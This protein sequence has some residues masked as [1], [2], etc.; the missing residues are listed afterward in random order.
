MLERPAGRAN[1]SPSARSC[2]RPA[3]RT[4]ASARVAA[5]RMRYTVHPVRL[6]GRQR[7]AHPDH[8]TTPCPFRWRA[9]RYSRSCRSKKHTEGNLEP[10]VGRTP[11]RWSAKFAWPPTPRRVH[12]RSAS[13][14]VF[15]SDLRAS[16]PDGRRLDLTLASPKRTLWRLR[17]ADAP[18]EASAATRISLTTGTGFSPRLAPNY[19]LYVSSTGTTESIWKLANGTDTELWSGQGARIF[20]GPAISPDGRY[21]AFSVRQLGQK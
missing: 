13:A 19:L 17:I 8:S 15:S 6:P 3:L 14:R 18:A 4:K 1:R 20:G 12:Q 21:I 16:E 10:A 2:R 11:C 7:F 5:P 9:S